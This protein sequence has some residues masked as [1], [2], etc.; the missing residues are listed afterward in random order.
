MQVSVL[1]GEMYHVGG[2]V[3]VR[4]QREVSYGVHLF[5]HSEEGDVGFVDVDLGTLRS[6]VLTFQPVRDP[7]VPL[8]CST[9][10]RR[11]RPVVQ[12]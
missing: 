8:G 1:L 6:A 7:D 5:L 3:R 12:I 4:H 10:L 9:L 2:S 11:H